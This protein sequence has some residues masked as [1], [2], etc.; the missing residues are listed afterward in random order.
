MGSSFTVENDS[1]FDM[2][3]KSDVH[4]EALFYSLAAISAVVI[5][6]ATMG[7]GLAISGIIAAPAPVLTAGG[8][9]VKATV[10]WKATKAAL[11]FSYFTWADILAG[12]TVF[13]GAGVV[14]LVGS[15]VEAIRAEAETPEMAEALVKQKADVE[16]LLKGFTHLAPGQ[17]FKFKGTLSLLQKVTAIYN[18]FSVADRAC[19]TAPL[20]KGNREYKASNDFR[21]ASYIGCYKDTGSDRVMEKKW[22]I[23]WYKS[24]KHWNCLNH[25]KGYEFYGLQIGSQCW[26]GNDPKVTRHGQESDK[27]CQN[28]GK[29]RGGSWLMAV[30]K[31][32]PGPLCMG[33]T[34]C[35]Q[36]K[37]RRRLANGD[38]NALSAPIPATSEGIDHQQMWEH[39]LFWLSQ[40]GSTPIHSCRQEEVARC[41]PCLDCLDCMFGDTESAKCMKCASFQCDT[42]AN[43]VPCMAVERECAEPEEMSE[44]AN[45]L[46]CVGCDWENGDECISTFPC[47]SCNVEEKFE[48][49]LQCLLEEAE[50]RKLRRQLK[51]SL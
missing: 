31:I 42:C 1:G 39:M 18:D 14:G 7:A 13:F 19:W 44:A 11:V 30:H 3:V 24:D 23:P 51:A 40:S 37:D 41:E 43:A 4:M 15:T 25:C 17:K 29:N 26:C 46:G 5:A 22:D 28:H 50:T 9:A 10:V 21:A 6:A 47:E 27:M 12:S 48:P 2:W 45:C 49:I 38:E 33:T 20:N 16:K 8:G 34:K 35:M 36:E 32:T